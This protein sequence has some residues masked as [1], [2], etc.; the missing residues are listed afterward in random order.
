[1]RYYVFQNVETSSVI[2]LFESKREAI[3][4]LNSAHHIKGAFN[5]YSIDTDLESGNLEVSS[6]SIPTAS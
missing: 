1:M 6:T 3:V 2:G 4:Y 5:L